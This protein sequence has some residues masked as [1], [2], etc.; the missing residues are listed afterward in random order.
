MA[1]RTLEGSF[2]KSKKVFRSKL[3]F[4]VFLVTQCFK[5]GGG[6][7]NYEVLT[8]IRPVDGDRAFLHQLDLYRIGY[9]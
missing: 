3:F 5:T 7:F 6:S 8:N 4:L 9:N 1:K 2:E